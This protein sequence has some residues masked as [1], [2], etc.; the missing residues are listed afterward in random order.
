MP[1][2]SLVFPPP[3]PHACTQSLLHPARLCYTLSLQYFMLLVA[4]ALEH[5]QAYWSRAGMRG[6]FRRPPFPD[7]DIGASEHQRWMFML[8]L[9]SPQ[10]LSALCRV[11]C[12][13]RCSNLGESTARITL[14]LSELNRAGESLPGNA[15]ASKTS[16]RQL[17][18]FASLWFSSA[19]W[20]LKKESFLSGEVKHRRVPRFQMTKSKLHYISVPYLVSRGSLILVVSRLWGS[21]LKQPRTSFKWEAAESRNITCGEKR[22]CIVLC[23]VDRAVKILSQEDT[24]C[25][26][27]WDANKS[28]T[29]PVNK[30]K[31]EQGKRKAAAWSTGPVFFFC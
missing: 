13:P 4:P 6:Q 29:F 19:F 22:S 25:I 18:A 3:S 1:S 10:H 14:H 5:L 24:Q 26:E 30:N 20:H 8:R 21:V 23:I 15:L 16:W 9:H 27:Q 31:R 28:T 17:D 12:A 11:R 7:P 2:G